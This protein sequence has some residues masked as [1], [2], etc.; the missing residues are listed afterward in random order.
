M[1]QIWVCAKVFGRIVDH[2]PGSLSPTSTPVLVWR[3]DLVFWTRFTLVWLMAI[4]VTGAAVRLTGSGLGCTDWPT[5]NV[6]TELD[7]PRFH[8]AIE[9][10][11]R[12]ISG[13]AIIPVI[14]VWLG[15][16]RVR[17]DLLLLVRLMVLGFVGQVLLGMLVTRTELDPRI[18]L[19]HFL[20]SI[21]LIFLG[22][23]LDH[24]ARAR[25]SP[26]SSEVTLHDLGSMSMAAALQLRTHAWMSLA[27]STVVIV[28]G[29]LVTGSGPHTGSDELGEP[30]ARLGFDIREITRIH[31]VTVWVLGALLAIGLWMTRDLD[32]PHRNRLLII[33]GLGASQ[34]AIGY[35]QYFTGVPAL[36]VGLHIAG[37][38]L[39]FTAMAYYTA[40]ATS[41]AHAAG[42]ATQTTR[43]PAPEL[44]S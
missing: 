44:A 11:N 29:T 43:R 5:C 14:A 8:S 42:Q 20:L 4:T 28:L 17:T 3:K 31:S 18:V 19:G 30:I 7:A 10:G 9:F 32:S 24:S 22:V 36:L 13:L 12:M 15:A 23:L 39:F 37:S 16:R 25:H 26:T 6:N 33:I 34:G 27:L 41:W 40:E 35:L 21:V 38:V 2:M 1:G